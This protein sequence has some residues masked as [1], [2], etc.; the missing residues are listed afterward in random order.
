MINISN[1]GNIKTDYIYE[2]HKKK[3]LSVPDFSNSSLNNEKF[4]NIN[5]ENL[6]AYHPSFTSF[7]N[8]KQIQEDTNELKYIKSKLDKQSIKKLE[9]LK[10]KGLLEN[11]NSNDGSTVLD[12]LYKIASEPRLKG[13]DDK[14]ILQEVITALDNPYSITQKF[15]DI[16]DS[17]IPEISK[18]TGAKIPQSAKK[19]VS[20]SCVAASMEFNLAS[21]FPAEFARFAADLSGKNYCVEKNINMSDFSENFVDG[22]WK[23]KEFNTSNKIDK[24]WKN[25]KIKLKPDRNAIVRARVQTSYKDKGERSCVDNLIQSTIMN[26]ASQGSYN[27]I[28]D[29]RTGKFNPD[30]T[31]LTD[32]EKNFAEQV[33]FEHPKYSVVYQNLDENGVLQSYNCSLDE[34]KQHILNSLKLGQNVIIGY[35]HLDSNNKVN[36]GHEITIVGYEQDEQGNGMFI[37]NDTDDNIDEPIVIR[38]EKLLP[39]IHHAGISKEALNPDDVIINSDNGYLEE[40]RQEIMNKRNNRTA[41]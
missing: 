34:T 20:S 18:E 39:L 30:R 40:L 36:G 35:T 21:R 8:S 6:K 38:E 22:I 12:N 16:P 10:Q 2:N 31:G 14:L 24:N 29:E 4:K 27:S 3:E 17:I 33:I 41:A 5:A 13:L 37:C 19:V 25:V 32:F 1:T 9:S 23:L 11:K 7:W 15:G 28:T 26:F